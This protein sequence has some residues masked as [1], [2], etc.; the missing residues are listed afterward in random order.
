MRCEG[1]MLWFRFC[2]YSEGITQKLLICILQINSFWGWF[3]HYIST[4]D[5]STLLI[6]DEL[7]YLLIIR[8][9]G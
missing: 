7:Q 3:I 9:V 2:W 1:A 4:V 6:F 5:Y 8:T